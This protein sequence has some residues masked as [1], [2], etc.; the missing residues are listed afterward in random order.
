MAVFNALDPGG[1][2]LLDRRRRIRVY[3]HIG[4]PIVGRLHSSA[5]LRFGVLDRFN[6]IVL[7]MT[8]ACY[9]EAFQGR[10]F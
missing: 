5:N 3:S 10:F 4:A 1:D 7:L 9:E 8:F 6:W 2:C